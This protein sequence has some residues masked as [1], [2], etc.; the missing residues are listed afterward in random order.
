MTRKSKD[1]DHVS[2]VLAFDLTHMWLI[3]IK[4]TLPSVILSKLK[5]RKGETFDLSKSGEIECHSIVSH[6]NTPS[7]TPH[8]SPPLLHWVCQYY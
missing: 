6:L 1:K 3:P 2:S 4:S 7:L 8:L 5:L